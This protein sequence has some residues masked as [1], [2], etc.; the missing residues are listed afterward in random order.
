VGVF[1]DLKKAF[2]VCSHDI[3]LKKLLKMGVKE[4]AH[5]W[6]SS[7]LSGREQCVDIANNF[8]DFIELA[9]SVIQGSTLGPILFLCYI[10]DFW[11]CTKMFSVLFADDTTC[12]SKGQDLRVLTT[13]VNVELQKMA[14]WFRANKM[15]VNTSKTKFI[16]FRTHGK[17]VNPEDCNILYNSNEIGLPENPDLIM[18][19]DRIS[20]LNEEK[21]FKL[22]G[23]YFDEYLAF[24]HHIT[25]LC[26]KISKSL[27]CINK[28]KNFIDV[29]SLKKLYYS[30][31]HSH[32]SYCINVY[33]TA[34]QTNLMKLEIKQKQAIRAISNSG[35]RDHTAPLFKKLNILP[36][37]KLITYNKVKFMHSYINRKLPISFAEMWISV[38][39]RNPNLALRNAN[40]LYV[41]PHRIELVK[42]LPLCAFPKA[43]NSMPEFKNNARIGKFLKD[44]KSHLLETIA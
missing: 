12:L 10:N 15:A 36:L 44:L 27:Y 39:E 32:I 4:D 40:D 38:R 5:A 16:I 22:L 20:N 24:D 18:P 7:Y 6:F 13:F 41:P 25:Q 34:N 2:D 8:S 11:T 43:W 19:I 42:R 29:V 9:I 30:M 1:L 28:I 17:Q 21:S 33:G 35:Y 14:N 3:L 26:S 23:V 31:V 37:E